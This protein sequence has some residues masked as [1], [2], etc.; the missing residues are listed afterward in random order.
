ML[1]VLKESVQLVEIQ[2]N[3]HNVSHQN[4][5]NGQEDLVFQLVV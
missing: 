4:F 5:Y 2:L 1:I 3:V